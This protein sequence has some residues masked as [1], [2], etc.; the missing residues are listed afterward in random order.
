MVK[1]GRT[2]I[3]RLFELLKGVR[4]GQQLFRLNLAFKSDLTWWHE[5]MGQ[6][7]GVAMMADPARVAASQH[8]YSDA[9]GVYGCG[10]WWGEERF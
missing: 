8:F 2:S 7:N 3:R 5:L 10:A 6:W 1:P 9:S 4:K